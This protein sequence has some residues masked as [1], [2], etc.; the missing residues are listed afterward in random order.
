MQFFYLFGKITTITTSFVFIV[1]IFTLL[2]GAEFNKQVNKGEN[3]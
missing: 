1:N 2:I 3:D